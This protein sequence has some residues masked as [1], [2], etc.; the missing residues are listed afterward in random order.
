VKRVTPPVTQ[1][2]LAQ[3]LTDQLYG[4]SDTTLGTP[5]KLIQPQHIT[6]T[7]QEPFGN[8]AF[9]IG[10]GALHGCRAVTIQTSSTE[11][12]LMGAQGHFWEEPGFTTK[13]KFQQYVLN[14][15]SRN[16]PIDPDKSGG[17]IDLSLFNQA[18]DDTRVFIMTPRSSPNAG[19]QSV[20]S[21]TKIPELR[22]MLV[23]RVPPGLLNNA[24]TAMWVYKALESLN[25][26]AEAAII[27]GKK[28]SQRAKALFQYD[29]SYYGQGQA[30]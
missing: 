24:P 4:T 26:A 14:V 20:N 1:D 5:T 15:I 18:N 12:I 17:P 9:S 27:D 25:N 11:Y 29:P 28:V 8:Q 19:P 21:H 13:A 2:N 30:G 23:G 6:I 10:T 16:G 22:N 3:C 7:V